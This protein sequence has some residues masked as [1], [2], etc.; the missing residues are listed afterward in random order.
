MG[1]KKSWRS[2]KHLYNL[3]DAKLFDLIQKDEIGSSV[4]RQNPLIDSIVLLVIAAK[5]HSLGAT[6]LL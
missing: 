4:L 2:R 5:N 1:I 3:S 6:I